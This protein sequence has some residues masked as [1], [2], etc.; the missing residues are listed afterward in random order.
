M[1]C[2]VR[3][4]PPPSTESCPPGGQLGGQDL[5]AFRASDSRSDTLDPEPSTGGFDH[6][7][8]VAPVRGYD[9][10][11][12]PADSTFSNGHVD[13]IVVSG[14]AGQLA[15]QARLV[16]THRLY[17][18]AGEHPR[19]A[20]LARA[21]APGFGDDGAGHGGKDLFGQE[22]DMQRPHAPVVS[23]SCD[24]RTRVISHPSHHADRFADAGLPDEALPSSSRARCKPSANSCSVSG[25]CSSSH[26]ATPRRPAS[27]LRRRDAVSAIQA[28]NDDPAAF[29]AWSMSFASSGGKETDRFSRCATFQR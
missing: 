16:G 12:T 19:Q 25:P 29:A 14:P 28:L 18:A 20:G 17:L 26:S 7:G 27:S 2:P 10:F 4:R 1:G 9:D 11:V 6:P 3:A 22:P 21:T 8:D 5:A 24:E 13:D 15:H 23:L